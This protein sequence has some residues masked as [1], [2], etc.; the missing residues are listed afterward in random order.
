[1][2]RQ[3]KINGASRRNFV[4]SEFDPLVAMLR[5]PS[6]LAS[7]TIT[8]QRIKA[9]RWHFKRFLN[10]I[11]PRDLVPAELHRKVY[12]VQVLLNLRGELVETLIL[13]GLQYLVQ[14]EHATLNVL[15]RAILF[16][17]SFSCQQP[18]TC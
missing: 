17:G 5:P 6:S 3:Q 4:L 18:S 10:V 13:S 15:D 8:G 7:R 2:A 14:R 16:V 11:P 1:M 12:V 9:V